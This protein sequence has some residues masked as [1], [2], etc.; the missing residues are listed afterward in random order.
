MGSELS[1]HLQIDWWLGS[2][3][4][5]WCFFSWCTAVEVSC[6][7]LGLFAASWLG[8]RSCHSQPR[9]RDSRQG[10]S[11]SHWFP[12]GSWR[13]KDRARMLC[14]L[15]DYSAGQQSDR[16]WTHRMAPVLLP[17][18]LFLNSSEQ[19]LVLFQRLLVLSESLSGYLSEPRLFSGQVSCNLS[20]TFR[21]QKKKI[22]QS[23]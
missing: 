22:K 21:L 5:G 14:H 13:K 3:P 19:A 15:S 4:G 17:S 10:G 20:A 16:M 9:G 12:R 18:G 23:F 7:F 11:E 8:T 1:A 2:A 6:L